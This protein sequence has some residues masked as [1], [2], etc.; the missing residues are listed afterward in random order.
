VILSDI[1]I[2]NKQKIQAR[3]DLKPELDEGFAL[4]RSRVAPALAPLFSQVVADRWPGS[5]ARPAAAVKAP[6]PSVA[7]VQ[8]ARVPTPRSVPAV[9]PSRAPTPMSVPAV[10]SF[11]APTPVGVP[12]VQ[13]FRAPTPMGVPAVQPA[14]APAPSPVAVQPRPA[15]PPPAP[16]PPEPLPARPAASTAPHR[17]PLEPKEAALRLARVMVSSIEGPERDDG[18]VGLAAE[19][20]EAR[21][22][23]QSC[24]LP[25]FEPLFD[26]ALAK[27]GLMAAPPPPVRRA[28]EPPPAPPPMSARDLGVPLPITAGDLTDPM[29]APDSFPEEETPPVAAA[30]VQPSTERQT[31]ALPRH[32]SP[33]LPI[34]SVPQ[35]L[36]PEPARP[37]MW[38]T[39]VA[40]AITVALAAAAYHFLTRP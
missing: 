16:A 40:T 9:Q 33:E 37:R 1:E 31:L 22:L 39:V 15:P 8:P 36:S 2:Y 29:E 10:Q 27:R 38:L 26:A 23:Y 17:D 7:A 34:I 24:V 3:A 4:F 32:S 35:P 19:I 18:G 21:T 28:P 14:R 20:E 5:A 6:S 12:A 13:P 30:P 25:E 11:R